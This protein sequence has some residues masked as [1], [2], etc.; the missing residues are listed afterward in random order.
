MPVF[1]SI[2]TTGF[3]NMGQQEAFSPLNLQNKT[4]DVKFI[5]G[6]TVIKCVDRIDITTPRF[7][8]LQ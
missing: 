8:M 6:V 1:Y 4:M 5:N 2:K 3:N 7:L